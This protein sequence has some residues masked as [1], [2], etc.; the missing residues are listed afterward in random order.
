MHN[1]IRLFLLMHKKE[2]GKWGEET[3]WRHNPQGLCFYCDCWCVNKDTS[4]SET[5][6]F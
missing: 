6:S 1:Q 2:Q 3:N 5:C 4:F